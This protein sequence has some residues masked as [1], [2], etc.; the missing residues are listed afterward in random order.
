MHR[1]L[2]AWIRYEVKALAKMA[3]YEKETYCPVPHV[4]V[5]LHFLA[6]WQTN[7]RR[8]SSYFLSHKMSANTLGKVVAKFSPSNNPHMLLK[9]WTDCGKTHKPQQ[10]PVLCF[11]PDLHE[12]DAI[13]DVECFQHTMKGR[14]LNLRQRTPLVNSTVPIAHGVIYLDSRFKKTL[15]SQKMRNLRVA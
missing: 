12:D 10:A 5:Y 7:M 15:L 2:V 6:N 3:D 11:L 13:D 8:T 14:R 1:W 9:N 4:R